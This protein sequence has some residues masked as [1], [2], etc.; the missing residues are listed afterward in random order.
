MPTASRN[1]RK[2]RR[3]KR[4]LTLAYRGLNMARKQR[5]QARLIA[6]GLNEELKKYTDNPFPE[7][8]DPTPIQPATPSLTITTLPDEEPTIDN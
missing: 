1:V 4:E 8:E 2:A 6:T 7:G 5:D 3:V